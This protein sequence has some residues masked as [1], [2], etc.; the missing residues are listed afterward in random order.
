MVLRTPRG[1]PNGE[2][3][4]L[5]NTEGHN[6]PTRTSILVANLVTTPT[7][8]WARVNIRGSEVATV[9]LVYAVLLNEG[10]SCSE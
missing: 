2:L 9:V 7:I 3:G 5:V 10:N 1:P 8:F 4:K 6:F